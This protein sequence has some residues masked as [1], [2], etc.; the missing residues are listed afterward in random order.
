MA[1]AQTRQI[2]VMVSPRAPFLAHSF[3]LSTQ[4]P[5]APCF[6]N[7][8]L[9][10]IFMPMILKSAS[11]LTKLQ[12]QIASDYCL[13]C[14][15]LYNSGWLIKNYSSIHLKSISAAGNVSATKKFTSLFSFS[16]GK[17]VIQISESV[18]I[19]GIIFNSNLPFDKLIEAVSRSS[20]YHIRGLL[21]ITLCSF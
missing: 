19:L 12:L 21:R 13:R 8:A 16:F 10:T 14:L 6:L 1:P 7:T 5:L 15:N 17:S 3:L 2:S 9:D 18:R 20:H 11:A 4:Y